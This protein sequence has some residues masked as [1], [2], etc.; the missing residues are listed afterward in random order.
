MADCIF[1]SIASGEVET[2]LVGESETAV[3]FRD[4]SPA[5][6]VH[7]LVVPREHHESVAQMAVVDGQGVADLFAL[8]GEVAD[9]EGIAG[10]GYRVLTNTGADAGQEV[11]HV[12]LHVVGGQPL[13][14]LLS[15][16]RG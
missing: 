8:V 12:H 14:A 5:A 6:P 9:G 4:Q 16:S 13:G 1:C 15:G 11:A 3:A 7:V 10:T 2:T